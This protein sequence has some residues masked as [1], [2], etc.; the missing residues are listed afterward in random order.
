MLGAFNKWNETPMYRTTL[1]KYKRISNFPEG[2]IRA[3][4]KCQIVCVVG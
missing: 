2:K 1:A 4:M 3:G